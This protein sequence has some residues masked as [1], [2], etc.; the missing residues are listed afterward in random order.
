MERTVKLIG[1]DHSIV[2]VWGVEEVR[3]I[4]IGDPPEE[5]MAVHRALSQ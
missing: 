4:V 1:L 2:A 3:L 5:G